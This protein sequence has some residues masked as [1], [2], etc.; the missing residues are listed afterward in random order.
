[1][2]KRF[3]SGERRYTFL[4]IVLNLPAQRL[5]EPKPLRIAVRIKNNSGFAYPDVFAQGE[6]EGLGNSIDVAT[7]TRRCFSLE[8]YRPA[9]FTCINILM[10]LMFTGFWWTAPKKQEYA[11]MATLLGV[12]AFDQIIRIDYVAVSFDAQFYHLLIFIAAVSV[13]IS[14]TFLGF[15]Y[16]RIRRLLLKDFLLIGVGLCLIPIAVSWFVNPL[17]WLRLR[18]F[19]EKYISS[20]GMFCGSFLLLSQA[21]LLSTK[22]DPYFTRTRLYRLLLFGFGLAAIA[23][24]NLIIWPEKQEINF[25]SRLGYYFLLFGLSWIIIE[26]YREAGTPGAENCPLLLS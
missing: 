20:F 25:Y 1:M 24:A 8:E 23:S 12:L 4:P 21:F 13:A 15:A 18:I 19:F 9:V 3:L 10:A 22:A 7:L 2:G 16:A 6:L 5:S 17:A 14:G 26:E 11:A